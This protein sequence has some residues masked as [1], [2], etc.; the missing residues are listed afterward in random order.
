MKARCSGE[1]T[2]FSHRFQTEKPS[3]SL[4]R[5][6]PWRLALSGALA[7]CPP[8]WPRQHHLH[9]SLWSLVPIYIPR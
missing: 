2:L 8:T 6:G 1:G 3:S 7:H 9:S 5:Q 4:G